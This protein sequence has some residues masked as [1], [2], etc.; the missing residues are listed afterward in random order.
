[1]YVNKVLPNKI[2]NFRRKII[3]SHVHVGSW[4]ENGKLKDYT[5][6]IDIFIKT[7][8]ENGDTIEKLIVSNLD[9]MA[10]DSNNHFLFDEYIG[11]KKI[12]DLANKNNKIA[13]LATCQPRYGNVENIVKLF[14][15]NP[16]KFIGFKFHPEQLNLAT[17][18]EAYFP[19]IEFA[20]KVNLPCLF[21]SG[22]SDVSNPSH[23][24]D[25]AKKFPDVKFIMAHW[26]AEEGGNYDKVTDII[27][28][29]VKTKNSQIYADISWV[30]CNNK[31]KPTLKKIITKLKEENALDRILFGS[32]APLGRF[33]GNGENGISPQK[34]YSE[35]IDDIKNMI[36]K[37]FS[38]EEAEEIINKIFYKNSEDL[39]FNKTTPQIVTQNNKIT[40]K[41]SK[42]FIW[43]AV[44]I[45]FIAGLGL[46]LKNYN[47]NNK[48]DK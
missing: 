29:S 36:K 34:A 16:N 7:N 12:L 18:N 27:I 47:Q 23:T 22:S 21:H 17:N 30:D 43:T 25:L 4:N 37:E 31:Q 45:T 10:K 19:Y 44:A 5:K 32:D 8:L 28:E 14:S 26:G 15:E 48:T 3:D 11:N 9:C 46:I 42:T 2:L 24:Y 39:F 35:L 1:M 13:P 40:K 38:Q 6:D 33:G 41:S 20:R